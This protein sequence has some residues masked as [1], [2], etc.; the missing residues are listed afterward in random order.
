MISDNAS[1]YVN[2]TMPLILFFIFK[3]HGVRLAEV[4]Q[5]DVQQSKNM[6]DVHFRIGGRQAD[7]YIRE[8]NL[9]VVT[10]DDI[11]EAL[12]YDGGMK[13]AGV[14]FISVNRKS[15]RVAKRF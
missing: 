12:I 4:I 9:G 6:V 3:S 2:L 8:K 11:A 10:P 7:K 5:P 15:K 13:G 14:D 1:C